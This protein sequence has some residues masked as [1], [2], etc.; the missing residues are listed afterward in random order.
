M[1]AAGL[2][3]ALLSR[4]ACLPASGLLSSFWGWRHAN[5]IHICC[6]VRYSFHCPFSVQ[7]Q[8]TKLLHMKN[9]PRNSG[10]ALLRPDT[11]SDNH[12][13]PYSPFKG[14]IFE[15]FRGAAYVHIWISGFTFTT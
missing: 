2:V 13:V 12:T 11:E 10:A 5:N 15:A 6:C 8:L 7:S 14:T 3:S 9:L 4:C 1:A